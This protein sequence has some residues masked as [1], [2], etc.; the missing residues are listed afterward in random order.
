MTIQ[1][2]AF[3]TSFVPRFLSKGDGQTDKLRKKE[4][5]RDIHTNRQINRQNISLTIQWVAFAVSSVHR[6]LSKG[7][8]QTDRQT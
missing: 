7:D 5:Q 6:F 3:A 2:V 8:I 1:W 4:R